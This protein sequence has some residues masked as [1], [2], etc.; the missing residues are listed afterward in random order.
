MT[1]PVDRGALPTSRAVALI[2]RGVSLEILRRKEFYVLLLLAGLYALGVVVVNVVGVENAATATFLLNLGLSFACLAAHMLVLLT[3]SRQIPDEMETR[4]LYPLLAK[5][6]LRSQYILGKWVAVWAGGGVAL[7]VL[8]AAAWAPTPKMQQFSGALLFQVIILQFVS[9][10]M[11]ASLA[12]LLSLFTPKAVNVVLVALVY[13]AGD[14]LASLI[15]SRAAGRGVVEWLTY[16]IPSFTDL[17]LV[18]RYTDGIG[19]LGAVEFL[20]L[21]LYGAICAVAALALATVV[22]DRRPL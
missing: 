1:T 16:Y 19:A 8:L 18:T 6:V 5:P 10:A 20:G 22:F 12:L 2:V 21:M 4:S 13:L 9:L 3:A 11:T 7:L 15:R 17:N 14:R